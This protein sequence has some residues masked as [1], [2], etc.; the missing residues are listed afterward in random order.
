MKEEPL[1]GAS[2][3]FFK[4]LLENKFSQYFFP[5]ASPKVTFLQGNSHIKGHSQINFKLSQRHMTLKNQTPKIDE[6]VLPVE[7]RIFR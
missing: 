5:M 6:I 1:R 7:I 4:N 2:K 3:Q